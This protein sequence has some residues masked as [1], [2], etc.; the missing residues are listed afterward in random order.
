MCVGKDEAIRKRV[1]DLYSNNGGKS[2]RKKEGRVKCKH[3]SF[4]LC[5]CGAVALI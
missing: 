5:V 4:T 1:P 2:E 3:T